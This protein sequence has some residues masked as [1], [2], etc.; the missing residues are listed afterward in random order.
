MAETPIFSIVTILYKKEKQLPFF[1]DAIL[2]QSFS[3][4]V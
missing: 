1:F 4:K 2:R 3:G